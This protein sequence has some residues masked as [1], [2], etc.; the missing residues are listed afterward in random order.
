MVGPVMPELAIRWLMKGVWVEMCAAAAEREGWDVTSVWR[1]I[2]DLLS[3]E[4]LVGRKGSRVWMK[5]W[6]VDR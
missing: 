3:W 4:G 2:I 6:R 1:G 5:E